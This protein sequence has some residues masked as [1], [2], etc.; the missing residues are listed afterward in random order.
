VKGCALFAAIF[1][2][3]FGMVISGVIYDLML[4]GG[5]FRQALPGDALKED[6]NELRTI[7]RVLEVGGVAVIFGAIY[8]A[9]G[10]QFMHRKREDDTP[11][12]PS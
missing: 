3:G 1:L 6:N 2:L 8:G 9:A 12:K 4:P 7:P 11:S 5:P 10:W